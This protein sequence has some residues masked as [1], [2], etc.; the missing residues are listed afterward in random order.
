MKEAGDT[1]KIT[2]LPVE[3]ETDI[4]LGLS[5][6]SLAANLR[7]VGEELGDGGELLLRGEVLSDALDQLGHQEQTVAV[8]CQELLD[9]FLEELPR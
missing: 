6:G 5:D 8:S 1:V 3:V 2:I 4:L 7:V 9:M